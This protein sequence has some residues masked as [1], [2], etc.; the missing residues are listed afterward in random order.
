MAAPTPSPTF[1]SWLDPYVT[2]LATATGLPVDQIAIIGGTEGIASLFEWGIETLLKGWLGPAI[3]IGLGIALSTI[4]FT[5]QW[6]S[7]R[8]RIELLEMG[9]HMV[10][11]IVEIFKP[12]KFKEFTKSIQMTMEAASVGDWNIFKNACIR[13][14]GE[15]VEG[16]NIFEETPS[17]SSEEYSELPSEETY[18]SEYETTVTSESTPSE[19]PSEESIVVQ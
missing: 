4:G 8:T 13:E 7:P 2:P 6:I 9:S 15:I 16:W 12:G 5:Q 3:E 19:L 17:P 14:P 10:S 18:T 11:R 1:T